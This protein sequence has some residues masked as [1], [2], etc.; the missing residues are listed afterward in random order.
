MLNSSRYAA[1]LSSSQPPSSSPDVHSDQIALA[2]ARTPLVRAAATARAHLATDVLCTAAAASP[3][4]ALSPSTTAP[5]AVQINIRFLDL[6]S[7]SQSYVNEY[8][9]STGLAPTDRFCKGLLRRIHHCNTELITRKDSWALEQHYCQGQE[10]IAKQLRYEIRYRILCEG[11]GIRAEKAFLSY[12]RE[13]LTGHDAYGIIL[14]THRIIGLFLHRN[15][16]S[17]YWTETPFTKLTTAASCL[18]DSHPVYGKVDTPLSVSC[19]PKARF[20]ETTQSFEFTPGYAINFTFRSRCRGRKQYEW[21]RV[22]SLQSKQN[23]PLNLA[24]AENLLWDTFNSVNVALSARRKVFHEEHKACDFLEGVVKCQHSGEDDIEVELGIENRLS[25][26]LSHL[27]RS[28]ESK[29]GLF[30]DPDARDCQETF[31]SIHGSL[32]RARDTT[33]SQIRALPDFD[34]RIMVLSAS[35]WSVETPARF[36]LDSSKSTSQQTVEAILERV[37]AGVSDVLCKTDCNIHLVAYKRGHLILDKVLVARP[38]SPGTG[39]LPTAVTVD[40]A[41]HLVTRLSKRINRDLDAI[42]KDSCSLDGIT[43][44]SFNNDN[45][46]QTESSDMDFSSPECLAPT[47]SAHGTFKQTFIH[48]DSTGAGEEKP[49]V[50]PPRLVDFP[51]DVFADTFESSHPPLCPAPSSRCRAFPLMPKQFTT[52]NLRSSPSV[53]I[54]ALDAKRDTPTMPADAP[55]VIKAPAEFVVKDV[56]RVSDEVARKTPP[57]IAGYFEGITEDICAHSGEKAIEGDA[58]AD[59]TIATEDE[60]KNKFA[61]APISGPTPGAVL[62]EDADSLVGKGLD[63]KSAKIIDDIIDDISGSEKQLEDII[64]E[65]PPMLI[66]FDDFEEQPKIRPCFEPNSCPSGYQAIETLFDYD[67]GSDAEFDFELPS[68]GQFDTTLQDAQEN[69]INTKISAAASTAVRQELKS[70]NIDKES[71]LGSI[72][73]FAAT[74]LDST[75][76]STPSLCSS[77]GNVGSPESSL[78]ETPNFFRERQASLTCSNPDGSP[79]PDLRL[80]GVYGDDTQSANSKHNYSGLLLDSVD[81]PSHS[82]VGQNPFG[83]PLRAS[84]TSS[85][86]YSFGY[87]TSSMATWQGFAKKKDIYMASNDS[88]QLYE[89]DSDLELSAGSSPE[90]HMFSDRGVDATTK[91]PASYE[92][93]KSVIGGNYVSEQQQLGDESAKQASHHSPEATFV[94]EIALHEIDNHQN[95][96]NLIDLQQLAHSNSYPAADAPEN[97]FTDEA[98][99]E[100][101]AVQELVADTL[102]D[103]FSKAAAEIDVKSEHLMY[104]DARDKLLYATDAESI[105]ELEPVSLPDLDNCSEKSFG[106]DKVTIS[107]IAEIISSVPEDG[108]ATI[109]SDKLSEQD[110]AAANDGTDQT[111]PDTAGGAESS[112]KWWLHCAAP[113][114][115]PPIDSRTKYL[116]HGF[117]SASSTCGIQIKSDQTADNH[118]DM[119]DLEEQQRPLLPS[120]N[121]RQSSQTLEA[122]NCAFFE[123][124][125]NLVSASE[126]SVQQANGSHASPDVGAAP[127]PVL[128]EFVEEGIVE[129]GV[130]SIPS[131]ETRITSGIEQNLART[132]VTDTSPLEQPPTPECYKMR[133]MDNIPCES[134]G[135]VRKTVEIV[136]LTLPKFQTHWSLPRCGILGLNQARST[137]FSLCGALP[138]PLVFDSDSVSTEMGQ[139]RAAMVDEDGID[140][141]EDAL[142]LGPQ[143]ITSFKNSV[144]NYR[145]Q[146]STEVPSSGPSLPELSKRIR[147]VSVSTEDFREVQE[148]ADATEVQQGMLPRVI[149]AFVSMAIMSQMINRSS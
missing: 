8:T 16:P 103:A 106:L 142:L 55:A 125:V 110:V 119:T 67:G 143:E 22:V 48:S 26:N 57:L 17:F 140:E 36:L 33:D 1:P 72:A 3:F 85:N 24:L 102:T 118:K 101:D 49:R 71:Y 40:Q 123:A 109:R 113:D 116:N 112:S 6:D 136:D 76:P 117:L 120:L 78:L 115:K 44:D 107:T 146:T 39:P 42:C 28:I 13:P 63:T 141:V 94:E 75:R 87:E 132:K 14:E 53:H 131:S 77:S 47:T 86:R 138:V 37:Q 137:R 25:P 64:I 23:A 99:V 108:H 121:S 128:Y 41:D 66:S 88:G 135:T 70:H 97:S 68:Y 93:A 83:Q 32:V 21:K 29:L 104:K 98:V 114:G 5:L 35:A 147:S 122:G 12:Q 149:I 15:D 60:F 10:T 46:N 144:L 81:L 61:A 148:T 92:Y 56:A 74:S 126:T 38:L 95:R 45:L 84:S 4:A 139:K 130:A 91:S 30:R 89:S 129:L 127:S 43:D 65:T 111:A 20:L 54:I 18:Q 124:A 82:L 19:V 100:T 105:F 7:Q 2:A 31:L 62:G 133:L 134:G 90:S 69:T 34:L 58:G 145:D 52:S 73:D 80:H 96:V 27:K 59:G 9:S 11:V 79:D 50:L 51:E